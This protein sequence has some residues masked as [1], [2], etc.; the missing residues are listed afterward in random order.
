M[1][2]GTAVFKGDKM[3]GT[4]DESVTRGLLWV[5]DEIKSA[6]ITVDVEEGEGK[7]TGEMIRS[8]T[9][10]IPRIENETWK[11]TINCKVEDDVIQN[12]STL[13]LRDP[14]SMRMLERKFEEKI[15]ERIQE[16]VEEVQQEM[17]VD[18]FNFHRSFQR[19]YT[20]EWQSAKV[21]WD[22]IF[23]TV[24]IEYDIDVKILRPGLST[25][26]P[27]VPKSEVE[28]I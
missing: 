18:I 11:I 9:K 19:K 25:D 26:P 28:D 16:A 21:N 10:L 23:P 14:K 2:S 4:L 8:Y 22:E 15:E 3:V 5:R 17:N 7:V 6:T 27:A 13:D 24:E 1:L 12:A 20:K